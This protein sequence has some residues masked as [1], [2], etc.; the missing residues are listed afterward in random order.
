M[1]WRTRARLAR[2]S[3]GPDD[4]ALGVSRHARLTDD[5][6]VALESRWAAR[7]AA[8]EV[9]GAVAL[10]D[11]EWRG[12][13]TCCAAPAR[14]R[15]P[16]TTVVAGARGPVPDWGESL[17][18]RSCDLISRLRFCATELMRTID[19]RRSR[20]YVTEQTTPLFAWLF[21]RVKQLVG[22]EFVTSSAER[23]RLQGY[24]DEVHGRGRSTLRHEDL[25][26][27]SF[28]DASFD[29]LLCLEVLEHVPNYGAAVRELARI[30]RPGGAAIFSAPFGVLEEHTLV[31]ATIDAQGTITH[32]LEPDYH[33]DP[34]SGSGCLC[35]YNFGWDLLDE[36]RAAGFSS[37]EYLDVW[38][39]AYGYLGGFA[40]FVA[41]R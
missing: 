26:Q 5:F 11:G 7:Q 1:R 8:E 18:C 24:L 34:A 31:R 10:A 30:L 3:R 25:T 27:L 37:A 28:R 23:A 12:Y 33:G 29:A 40:V 38:E 9:L 2:A 21:A 36:I 16:A 22:S 15:V 35:F 4:A 6:R 13:C 19:P 41:R 17:R 39:P 20:V 14:F 32:L